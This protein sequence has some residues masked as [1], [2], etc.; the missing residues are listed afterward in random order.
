MISDTSG[1]DQVIARKR[2]PQYTILIIAG[3]VLI[4][5]WVI[6]PGLR[7]WSSAD[8]SFDRAKLRFDTVT[9]GDLISDVSVEG[10]IVASSYPTL[11]SPAEGRV[12]LT[13]KAGQA[14]KKGDVLARIDSPELQSEVQQQAS[15]VAASEAAWS[16][17]EIEAKT[18]N[19]LNQQ[20]I[21]LKRLRHETAQRA[22]T[23][24]KTSFDQGLINAADYEAA[25]D[26]VKI[27]KLEYQNARANAELQRER[28]A[29]EVQN[30]ASILEGQ[31][32]VLR[33]LKRRVEE[34]EVRSPVDGVI[35]SLSVDP[36]DVVNDSQPLLTVIDLSAFEIQ[37]DVPEIYG[38]KIK[39]GTN[40]E[41]RYE[42]QTYPGMV[43]AIS[44][45]VNQSFVRG[46]V[47]FQGDPPTGLKQNQRVTVRM[48]LSSQQNVLKVRRGPFLDSGNGREVFIV[49]DQVA[50]RQGVE[51]G[52]L[53][54]SEV[55]I[56]SG[57][58]EGDT[59]II[60]DISRFDG[61]NKI[62]LKN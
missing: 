4:A 55:E 37:I 12:T 13:A 32:L 17:Q 6:L 8:R 3:I 29:F 5:L 19:L 28:L 58:Q 10:R 20:D 41:V 18:T 23:R 14:V 56:R 50:V 60:S 9:L 53:S 62:F 36:T 26:N 54:I 39:A 1:Q 21:E 27:A 44:P 45:E 38:D 2:R 59:I 46:T 43:I 61:A 42:N 34:L 11:Y 25:D 7:T 52:E 35:G 15:T 16:R 47:V 30:Q 24:A 31:R 22:Y 33:E 40:A 48:I 51:I 49:R 57:L